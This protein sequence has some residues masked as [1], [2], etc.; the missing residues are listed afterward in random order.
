M[1]PSD[2]EKGQH[3]ATIWSAALFERS[4]QKAKGKRQKA[5]VSDTDSLT[6]GLC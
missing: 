2:L 1:T 3:S 5:K 6:P 4:R